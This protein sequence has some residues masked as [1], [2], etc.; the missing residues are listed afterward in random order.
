MG[1][2]FFFGAC[3]TEGAT[4]RMLWAARWPTKPSTWI[5]R[6]GGVLN[7]SV[8]FHALH[9]DGAFYERS[10]G[11]VVFLRAARTTLDETQKPWPTDAQASSPESAA[12]PPN[13]ASP[14]TPLGP[15]SC[16]TA[17]A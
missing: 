17:L 1:P 7:L 12:A 15:S 3:V 13:P 4:T 10:D 5:Q 11:P 2:P 14:A 9:T 8:H 6:C 16:A